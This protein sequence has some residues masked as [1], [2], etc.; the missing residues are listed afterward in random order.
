MLLFTSTKDFVKNLGNK[1]RFNNSLERIETDCKNK[2]GFMKFFIDE[3]K[4]IRLNF[5]TQSLKQV[6]PY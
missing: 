6:M 2:G 1:L 4:T 3:V 5:L